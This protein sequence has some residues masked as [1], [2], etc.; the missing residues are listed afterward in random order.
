MQQQREWLTKKE[1]AREVGVA[2]DTIGDW[3][4]KGSLKPGR[5]TPSGRPLFHRKDLF[6]K[7]APRQAS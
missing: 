7:R 4:R 6:L 3:V 1:A 5:W 2:V